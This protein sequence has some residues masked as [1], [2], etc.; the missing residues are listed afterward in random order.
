MSEEHKSI[1]DARVL[2][3]DDEINRRDADE[4]DEN[5]GTI[6]QYY[7]EIRDLITNYAHLHHEYVL[8]AQIS[9]DGRSRMVH[10]KKG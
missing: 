1:I 8:D 3:M 9:R 2:A 4:D 6:I 7:Y 5:E 10:D